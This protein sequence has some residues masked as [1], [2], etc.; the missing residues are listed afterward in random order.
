MLRFLPPL[1][2]RYTQWLILDTAGINRCVDSD[3]RINVQVPLRTHTKTSQATRVGTWVKPLFQDPRAW[4]RCL[5]SGWFFPPPSAQ[6]PL[7]LSAEG[8]SSFHACLFFPRCIAL[9]LANL[10]GP[11]QI[12]QA[13]YWWWHWGEKWPSSLSIKSPSNSI[14]SNSSFQ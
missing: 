10:W 14:G 13:S 7:L 11:K 2:K 8:R 12:G 4:E 5:C 9:M 1:G 3:F 6:A